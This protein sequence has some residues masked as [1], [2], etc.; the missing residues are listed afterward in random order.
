MVYFFRKLERQVGNLHPFD[1]Q[2]YRLTTKLTIRKIEKK[3]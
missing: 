1:R 3:K 2:K